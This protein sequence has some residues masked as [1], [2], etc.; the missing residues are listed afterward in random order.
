MVSK[1]VSRIGLIFV[2]VIGFGI[3][4]PEFPGIVPFVLMTVGSIVYVLAGDN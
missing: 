4:R 1:M 3:L 2:I